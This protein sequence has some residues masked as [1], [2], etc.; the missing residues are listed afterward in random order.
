MKRTTT[1]NNTAKKVK[2]AAKQPWYN[3]EGKELEKHDQSIEREL[4]LGVIC[5]DEIC[6]W[7]E[8]NVLW[9][10]IQA[11]SAKKVIRL[12]IEF[13]N[14]QGKAPRQDTEGLYYEWL[15]NE[16]L[17]TDEAEELEQDI[18]PDLSNEAEQKEINVKYLLQRLEHYFNERR[19]IC[20]NERIK[21]LVESGDHEEAE[22][23]L[24]NYPEPLGGQED[25]IVRDIDDF[26]GLERPKALIKPWL[27]EGEYSLVYADKGVGKSMLGILIAYLLASQ[28]YDKQ[29]CEID[30]GDNTWQVKNTAKSLF[31]AGEMALGIQ[32]R[33]E[34]FRKAFG[35]Y[36]DDKKPGIID[37]GEWEY[38]TEKPF[39]LSNRENQRKVIKT[40]KQNP[41]IKLVVLDN[42]QT[43]F[44]LEDSNRESEWTNK[45]NPLLRDLEHL[46]VACLVLD[47]TGKDKKQGAMG[48][49]AKITRA[50]NIIYLEKHPEQYRNP[51]D[52]WFKV[53]P[54]YQRYPDAVFNPFYLR[55]WQ[56]DS[57]EIQFEVTG[58]PESTDNK[59]DAIIRAIIEGQPQKNIAEKFGVSTGRVSQIGK[60][61]KEKGLLN[62]SGEPTRE[63]F[64]L[65]QDMEDNDE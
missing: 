62:N 51:K 54:K 21:N 17:T 40:L 63:G 18:L 11:P 31:I 15:R 28:N 27:R 32:E 33:F 42:V 34:Q 20:H 2:A 3:K 22:R 13:Y 38:K 19:I 5:K 8:D 30:T 46:G 16:K 9:E 64:S 7:V 29:E 4:T 61:A 56:T 53:E 39:S 14:K 65:I 41:N 25:L 49:H 23:L 52:A 45:V 35:D 44:D 48:T 47:H 55:F 6:Q 60:D 50:S 12:V 37:R 58:K 43:L 10:W 57:S 24:N 1:T 36:T 59:K 26:T